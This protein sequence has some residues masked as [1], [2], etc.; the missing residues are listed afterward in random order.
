MKT[1]LKP[2]SL[3]MYLL[4]ILVFFMVWTTI[5]GVTGAGKGQ[6]LAGGAIV[7]FYGVNTAII[8]FV[9][10][11][12]VA[13][14]AKVGNII[15]INKYLGILLLIAICLITYRVITHYNKEV[16][17]KEYPTEVT[18]PAPQEMSLLSYKE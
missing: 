12:F 3:L 17:V 14:K 18:T 4:V 10:S 2:A 5:A 15:K 6:G 8:A 13:N 1:L 7:F 11:L 9:A 16:T